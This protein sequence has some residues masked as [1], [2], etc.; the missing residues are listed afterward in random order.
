MWSRYYGAC[1]QLLA[2]I[3]DDEVKYI[4]LAFDRTIE[5]IPCINKTYNE[6]RAMIGMWC[7]APSLRTADWL[8]SYVKDNIVYCQNQ[9][10]H[11]YLYFL[12]KITHWSNRNP[13]RSDPTI[14]AVPNLE[15]V[16][17]DHP[18]YPRTLPLWEKGAFIYLCSMTSPHLTTMGN[19]CILLSSSRFLRFIFKT[20]LSWRIS[21][22]ARSRS[23]SVACPPHRK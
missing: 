4:A 1:V 8:M 10:Y 7:R 9:I 23:F 13:G 19:K 3:L 11:A 22:L 18:P 17:D 14:S 16:K 2:K 12:S 20:W 6:L 15:V 5:S 21:I